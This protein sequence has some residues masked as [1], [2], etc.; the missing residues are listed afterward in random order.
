VLG[1]EVT[2][3]VLRDWRTAPVD[4]GTRAVLGFLEKLTL[5]PAEVGPADADAVRAAGVSDGA[6]REAIYVAVLFNTID[7][8]ADSL[9]FR[10][11]SD[12]GFKLGARFLL[13]A[14]YRW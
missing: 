2:L 9:D 13:R 8:I 10:V 4:E 5:S 14:G 7:R 6:L 1:E 3:A 11:L 12:R